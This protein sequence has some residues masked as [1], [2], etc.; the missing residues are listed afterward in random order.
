M[1]HLMTG[2]LLLASSATAHAEVLAAA[3]DHYELKQEAVS[4]LTPGELWDR[5]IRASLA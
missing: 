2:T 1:K 4:T 5:R 3:P